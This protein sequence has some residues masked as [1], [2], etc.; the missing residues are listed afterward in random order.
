MILV[1]FNIESKDLT[2]PSNASKNMFD[3]CST[4]WI[5]LNN[6]ILDKCQALYKELCRV[7]KVTVMLNPGYIISEW[8]CISTVCI[9]A[10]KLN[11]L[12]L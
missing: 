8:E 11:H 2:F 3:F 1:S 10:V 5:K 4:I 6:K 7:L 12:S 9:P